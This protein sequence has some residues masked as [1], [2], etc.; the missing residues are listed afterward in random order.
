MDLLHE[1]VYANIR[2]IDD[3]GK[4]LS[5]SKAISRLKLSCEE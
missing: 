1:R 3:L 4:V 2:E 5:D